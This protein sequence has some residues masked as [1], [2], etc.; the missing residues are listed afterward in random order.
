[1][2][3]KLLNITCPI[4]FIFKF[5]CPTCGVTRALLSL[6]QLDFKAYYKFNVMAIP[7]LFSTWVFVHLKVLKKKKLPLVV[8]TAVLIINFIYYLIRL[9][10]NN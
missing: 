6:L 5:P 7:L 2:L 3:F 10:L 9:F 4:L 8:A 1:M